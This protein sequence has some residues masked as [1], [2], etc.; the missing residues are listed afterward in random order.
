MHHR[1]LAAS[2][3]L[4]LAGV[5]PAG[6]ITLGALGPNGSVPEGSVGTVAIGS[7]GDIFE[8][9]A[10]VHIAGQDLNGAADGESARLSQDPLPSGLDLLFSSTLSDGDSDWTL[11]YQLT[12]NTGGLLSG[13]SVLSYLDAE[14]D[15]PL[16]SF[17]NEFVTT[18]GSL[19]AGQSFEA[20]EPGFLFGD[21][22]DN[23]L[24]GS[25]DGTNAVDA[26]N[27]EDAAMALAFLLPDLAD[28]DIALIRVM[29]SED[30]D[31]L[32]SFALQQADVDP[33]SSDVITYSAALEIRPGEP[34][35][36]AIPE[37]R[38]ALLFGAG[39]WMLGF[40]L[41]RRPA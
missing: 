38:A 23:V 27:P 39:A 4:T 22:L 21:I 5:T 30:G 41:R 33:R 3:L 10:F 7:G 17:F 28:G 11:T 36:P 26:A 8:L 2:V 34:A 29:I 35:G 18:S 1:T 9:D 25:L 31:R 13:V 24:A 14:I 6:A 37:P 16:N 20:D 19:A 12:N 15:E 32:G 40:A